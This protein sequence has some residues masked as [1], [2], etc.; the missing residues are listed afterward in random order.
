MG[1]LCVAAE[2]S[3]EQASCQTVPAAVCTS[4]VDGST[5]YIFFIAEQAYT[6]IKCGDK[7]G[8]LGYSVLFSVVK[9]FLSWQAVKGTAD[10]T[11]ASF[12]QVF[13]LCFV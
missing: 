10:G 8:I 9:K 6:V 3:L 13:L 4:A 5:E 11:E 2:V 7:H 12:F 1:Y